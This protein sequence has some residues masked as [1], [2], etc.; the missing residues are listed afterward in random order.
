MKVFNEVIITQVYAMFLIF[1]DG[2]FEVNIKGI[3][4]PLVCYEVFLLK[5][6]S[7]KLIRDNPY[8][9]LDNFS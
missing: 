3:Y 4:C 5:V 1:P 9:I 8:N 6:F 7:Y 2:V